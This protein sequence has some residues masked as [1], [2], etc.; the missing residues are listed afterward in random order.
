MGALLFC[1]KNR[2]ISGYSPD[3]RFHKKTLLLLLN[4]RLLADKRGKRLRFT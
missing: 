2:L 3:K 4:L 1:G